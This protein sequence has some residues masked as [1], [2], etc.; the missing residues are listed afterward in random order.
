MRSVK[1]RKVFKKFVLALIDF[2]VNLLGFGGMEIETAFRYNLPIIF[3]IFN[4][5]G[6]YGGLEKSAFSEIQKSGDPC[7]KY[8]KIY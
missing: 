3:V 2:V 5:N 7:I 4:N 6:I 8:N 1:T